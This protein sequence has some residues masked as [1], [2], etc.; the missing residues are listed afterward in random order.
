MSLYNDND[1]THD[2]LQDL[3][4]YITMMARTI[5]ELKKELEQVRD[6]LILAHEALR[7]EMP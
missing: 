4:R 7:R 2:K 3:S 6:E 1:G 5:D